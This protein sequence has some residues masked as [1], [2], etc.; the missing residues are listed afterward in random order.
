MDL[1]LYLLDFGR[2]DKVPVA[3]CVA[4]PAPVRDGGHIGEDAV[5]GFCSGFGE[6]EVTRE[7]LVE[8]G[9]GG[10]ETYLVQ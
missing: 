2:V 10:Y 5:D 4:V 9:G 7:L 1:P 3:A 6:V 8:L